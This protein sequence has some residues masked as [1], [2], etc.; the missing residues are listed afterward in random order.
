MASIL[1]TLEVLKKLNDAGVEY[2]IIGGV[3]AILH[4]SPRTTFDIDVCVLL[5]EPNL[6]RIVSMLRGLNPRFR[7]RPD[8]LPMPDDPGELQGFRNLHLDTDLGTIDFLT[9]VTG[10]G[11]YENA[12][13]Q[14]ELKQVGGMPCRVLKLDALIAA[15]RAA[16]RM[17]DRIA[18]LELEAI[19][20]RLQERGGN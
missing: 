3:A 18:V 14:S 20:K 10:V 11:T 4:G 9:E 13:A 6:T 15:K 1:R 7:M 2:V 12:F 5:T 17:K 8:K 19:R 16:N